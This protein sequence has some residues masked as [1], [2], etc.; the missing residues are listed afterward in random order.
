MDRMKKGLTIKA[1]KHDNATSAFV[2]DRLRLRLVLTNPFIQPAKRFKNQLQQNLLLVSKVPP[3]LQR[4]QRK[5]G[6]R[7]PLLLMP[8]WGKWGQ[9]SLTLARARSLEPWDEG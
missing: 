4:R 9:P 6:G 5:M 1:F 2:C 8:L 7:A 3:H